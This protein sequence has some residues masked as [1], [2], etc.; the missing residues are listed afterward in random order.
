M[1]IPI[2]P[3]SDSF[4]IQMHDSD[5]KGRREERKKS[6]TKA[7]LPPKRLLAAC[8]CFAFCVYVT[9]QPQ[10][11]QR[12]GKECEKRIMCYGW[13]MLESWR[14]K[15]KKAR[16]LHTTPSFIIRVRFLCF[17]RLGLFVDFLFF[18]RQG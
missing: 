17:A 6:E 4:S 12:E 7:H 8:C 1:S 2:G 15:E 11:W 9:E 13:I 10:Q 18:V 5:P 3:I 14:R 16:N